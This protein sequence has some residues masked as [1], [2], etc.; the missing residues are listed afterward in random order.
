MESVDSDGGFRIP[1]LGPD[2]NVGPD[3]PIRAPEL[4]DLVGPIS[5][6][7]D[8]TASKYGISSLVSNGS[9]TE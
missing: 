6:S 8:I 2:G 3:I 4:F 7:A 1:V 9:G 5:S